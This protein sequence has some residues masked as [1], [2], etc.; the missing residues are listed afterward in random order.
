MEVEIGRGY[1]NDEKS[2]V[3]FNLEVG[4]ELTWS[5]ADY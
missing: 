5:Y 2:N 4:D 1:W 3:V